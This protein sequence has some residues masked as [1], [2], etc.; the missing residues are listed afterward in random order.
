MR[1]ANLLFIVTIFYLENESK[2]KERR[3]EGKYL[4]L[5]GN[6]YFKGNI[7][8]HCGYYLKALPPFFIKLDFV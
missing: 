7:R 5:I 3:M 6:N 1:S 4:F 8:A 2:K